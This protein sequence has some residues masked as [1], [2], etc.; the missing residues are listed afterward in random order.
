MAAQVK[1]KVGYQEE[2]AVKAAVG[3][4]REAAEAAAEAYATDEIEKHAQA[5][6]E[7][8]AAKMKSLTRQYTKRARELARGKGSRLAGPITQTSPQYPWWN[9]LIAG[10]YQPEPASGGPYMP[11]KIFTASEEAFMIGGVW[12]NPEPINWSPPGP[13]AAD[14]MAGYDLTIRFETIN[15]TSV[16]AGPNLGP[17]EMKPIFDWPDGDPDFK[18]FRVD[19]GP[20]IFSEPPQ[21]RPHLY[22]L[23]VTADITGPAPQ[24]MA[25]FAT[26]VF[27]PDEE[28]SIWPLPTW[29]SDF[30]PIEW[31]LWW[32]P[33]HW[34]FERPARFLV[35]KR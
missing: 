2:V 31:F 12:L 23:N 27:D 24:A 17:I 28:P 25:G 13:S 18:T 30:P 34:Q 1:E 5:I 14:L 4:V 33:Q 35:Y 29:P 3:T 21:G 26:W 11:H 32:W 15:L 20:G 22:E 16:A 9:V 7:A 19:L 10:P 8:W 6:M